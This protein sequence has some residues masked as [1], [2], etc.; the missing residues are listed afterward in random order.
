MSRML[1]V[2]HYSSNAR[3]YRRSG[4]EGK[5]HRQCQGCCLS[6]HTTLT[7]GCIVSPVL[8]DKG[9]HQTPS[10]G[11][12]HLLWRKVPISDTRSVGTL[13]V[14]RMLVVSRHGSNTMLF[15][16]SGTS[17]V[18]HHSSNGY[19][20]ISSIKMSVQGNNYG[21]FGSSVCVCVCV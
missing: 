15:R 21:K 10:T 18:S 16:Q 3:V 4:A 8:R 7:P 6:V 13:S 9:Y 5:R 12:R 11:L 19:S 17:E 14:P 2:S 20:H 1:S